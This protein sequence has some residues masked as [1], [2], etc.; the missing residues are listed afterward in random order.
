M[1]CGI[2]GGLLT[3][4]AVAQP[5]TVLPRF[6]T[7]GDIS[8]FYL[9]DL[10]D[11]DVE[12]VDRLQTTA[13]RA[14]KLPQN[15][16]ELAGRNQAARPGE[17]FLLPL[18]RGDGRVDA[19]LYVETG[20]GYVAYIDD[21]GRSNDTIGDEYTSMV[22]RPFGGIAVDGD[23]GYV[24]I[25]RRLSNETSIGAFLFH[26]PSGRALY[27]PDLDDRPAEASTT[28]TTDL[29]T[30]TRPVTAIIQDY[31]EQTL[32]AVVLDPTSGTFHRFT[33]SERGDRLSAAPIGPNLFDVF[34]QDGQAAG[35][36]R[37]MLLPI[38]DRLATLN[39]LVL[40]RATGTAALLTDVRAADTTSR[41]VPLS[42]GVGGPI[43]EGTLAPYVDNNRTR[44][45]WLFADNAVR[46][47]DL[48]SDETTLRSFPV[49]VDRGN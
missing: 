38:F 23:P 15:L 1:L 27:L 45:A 5:A 44:G 48:E 41:L 28:E 29:P 39:V 35:E 26:G 21:L 7:A 32:G 40:D 34:A 36:G 31:N 49:I 12:L 3:G 42:G 13:L 43:G 25:G 33:V 30:I 10:T 14:R 19:A 46:Y 4:I 18:H 11:G 9:I 16:F 22:G 8:N 17:L 2:L 47:L 6:D 37:F 20:I 24:L